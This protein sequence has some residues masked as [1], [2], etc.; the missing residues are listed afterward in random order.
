MYAIQVSG[1]VVKRA[2]GIKRTALNRKITF[3]NYVSCLDQE[4]VVLVSFNRIQSKKHLLS[5]VKQRKLALSSNDNKRHICVNGINTIAYGHH[6][7]NNE[8]L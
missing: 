4:T 6:R 8:N 7:L 1:R 5:S 3:E 2:K